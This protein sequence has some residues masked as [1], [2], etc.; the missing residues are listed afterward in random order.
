MTF[1]E[2]FFIILLLFGDD[3]GLLYRHHLD[4]DRRIILFFQLYFGNYLASD[5]GEIFGD[6]IDYALHRLIIPIKKVLNV[7]ALAHDYFPS[8]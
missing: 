1:I 7:S 8:A 4:V 2:P 5:H 3:L 6:L